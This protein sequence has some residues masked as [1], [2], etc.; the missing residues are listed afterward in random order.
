MAAEPYTIV[1]TD[2]NGE[3]M[4]GYCRRIVPEGAQTCIPITYCLIS[5]HRA[6]GFYAKVWSPVI[7]YYLAASKEWCVFF[8]AVDELDSIEARHVGVAACDPLRLPL[9]PEV[10]DTG[11]FYRVPSRQQS[12]ETAADARPPAR[13]YR[14]AG[15][16]RSPQRSNG[17]PHFGHFAPRE[18]AHL[19][20]SQSQVSAPQHNNIFNNTRILVFRS[21][22]VEVLSRP[23][24]FVPFLKSFVKW[25]IQ[26]S[27]L[28]VGVTKVEDCKMR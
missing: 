1:L 19:H 11:P 3:R 20:Q 16:L 13:R 9:R 24:W 26:E 27:V 12:V 2:A 15:S 4:Y 22:R 21:R 25:L 23:R 6:A 5:R 28:E 17:P 7:Y 10:S 8:V 18:K 14:P